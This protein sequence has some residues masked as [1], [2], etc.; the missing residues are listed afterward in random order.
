MTSLA[1]VETIGTPVFSVQRRANQLAL[2]PLEETC[3]DK[4]GLISYPCF[5]PY[6]LS[7]VSTLLLNFKFANGGKNDR[8]HLP[9]HQRLN[10]A[11]L[12]QA[13]ERPF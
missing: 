4:G 13:S 12:R 6:G 7:A 2:V 3:G 8:D 10:E 5:H 11:D 9:L 1:G